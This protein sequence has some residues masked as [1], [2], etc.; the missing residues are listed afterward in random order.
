MPLLTSIVEVKI[1]DIWLALI[2]CADDVIW[3]QSL[4]S[5]KVPPMFSNDDSIVNS[6]YP[7]FFRKKN[8]LKCNW[9]FQF[10]VIPIPLHREGGVYDLYYSQAAGGNLIVLA[11]LWTHRTTTGE[12]L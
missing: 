1:S 11:S 2:Y 8:N 6:C 12:T 3:L 5:N 10:G 4:R 9:I 7:A